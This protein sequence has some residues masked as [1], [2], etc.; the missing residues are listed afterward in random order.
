MSPGD[1]DPALAA[2]A[3]RLLLE[4]SSWLCAGALSDRQAAHLRRDV[5]QPALEAVGT[6]KQQIA[7]ARKAS[8]K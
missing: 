7:A 5:V 4:A 1:I 8:P 6:L 2:E 3:W